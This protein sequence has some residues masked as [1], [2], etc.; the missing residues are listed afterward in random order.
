MSW[1]GSLFVPAPRAWPLRQLWLDVQSTG[2]HYAK[3]GRVCIDVRGTAY[4]AVRGG[5]GLRHVRL[6]IGA[7]SPIPS[8]PGFWDEVN[9]YAAL[10][11]PA[12]TAWI[13]SVAIA[14]WLWFRFLRDLY[15]RVS[16]IRRTATDYLDKVQTAKPAML[17]TA[18]VAVLQLAWLFL[19]WVFAMIMTWVFDL[20]QQATALQWNGWTATYLLVCGSLLTASYAAA[21]G[22]FER[23]RGPACRDHGR[24][25]IYRF[26]W[27]PMIMPAI[28]MIIGALGLL[29]SLL[30]GTSYR[31]D[32]IMAGLFLL[33]GS[34]GYIA[35]SWAAVAAPL[36]VQG[37]W[38]RSRTLS[39]L[40]R[41]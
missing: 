27:V 33:L 21:F 31:H 5:T 22:A 13:V 37:T 1:A 34:A 40:S 16:R 3:Q 20:E 7:G 28:I 10:L 8:P 23:R 4:P 29:V 12:A 41:V 38:Q 19:T 26:C 18:T 39:Q 25:L 6:Y 32:G 17:V 2:L 9:R 14:L 35:A 30:P 36:L 15:R 24:E 11:L